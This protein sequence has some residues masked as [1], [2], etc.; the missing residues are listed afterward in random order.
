MCYYFDDIVNGTKINFSSILFDKKLNDNISVYH[1][2]YKT[3]AGL[4]PLCIKFSKIDGFI[5]ALDGKINYLILFDHELFNKTCDRIK[6]LISKKSGITNNINHNFGKIRIDSYNFLPI[7]KI[8]SFYNVI[9]LITSVVNKNKNK[10]YYN[11]FFIKI[12]R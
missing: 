2:S 5:I 4:K 6:Y 10:Y 12:Y 8:L 7:K 9:I 11:I 3:P 1:I